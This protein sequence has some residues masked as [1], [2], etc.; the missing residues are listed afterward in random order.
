MVLYIYIYIYSFQEEAVVE[1]YRVE[2]TEFN[3]IFV[4]YP[5]SL[6]VLEKRIKRGRRYL[7]RQKQI[8]IE[9]FNEA[10]ASRQPTQ[11]TNEEENMETY[12]SEAG[13]FSG[14]DHS[15]KRPREKFKSIMQEGD[16]GQKGENMDMNIKGEN[17]KVYEEQFLE[18]EGESLRDPSEDEQIPLGLK[19]KEGNKSDENK[20]K[21]ED[22]VEVE[23][24][25]NKKVEEL[26]EEKENIK[27]KESGN[28]MKRDELIEHHDIEYDIEDENKRNLDSGEML[29]SEQILFDVR[30]SFGGDNVLPTEKSEIIEET[31]DTKSEVIDTKSEVIDTKS[32]SLSSEQSS[33]LEVRWFG[34]SLSTMKPHVVD[35]ARIANL[36]EEYDSEDQSLD[37]LAIRHQLFN[38]IEHDEF[39]KMH[40]YEEKRLIKS[41]Q[42]LVNMEVYIYIYSHILLLG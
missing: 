8:A 3:R 28:N 26:E 35:A 11:H 30:A 23:K 41:K 33:Q 36:E 2:V 24:R 10:L 31:K 34:E 32:E 14:R 19:K 15:P 29:E 42:G 1:V 25:E 22:V 6:K 13:L 17:I 9:E 16:M 20:E 12:A 38:D 40:N 27:N 18:E 5:D 37:G 21:M 7:R 4:I 39:E